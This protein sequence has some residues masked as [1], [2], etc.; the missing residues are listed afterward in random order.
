MKLNEIEMLYSCET[1]PCMKP[2]AYYCTKLDNIEAALPP[3]YQ[4][5]AAAAAAFKK[6][7]LLTIGYPVI[8]HTSHQFTTP[9]LFLPNQGVRAMKAILKVPELN[10]W[11]NT[12]HPAT[13]MMLPTDSN[14]HDC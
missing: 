8:L 14:S 5:Q 6:A 9:D 3:S 12:A 1:P 2:R 4:D 13:R 11:C 7:S 10:H